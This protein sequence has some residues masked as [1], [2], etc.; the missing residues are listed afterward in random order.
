MFL[1]GF[2]EAI[3]IAVV[4]VGVY[5]ALNVVVVAVG[6][7]ARASRTPHVV[8]DWTHGADHRS[9]ATRW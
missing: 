1:K 7:R 6:A 9:T 8:G 5:L 3:G 4:L 2:N